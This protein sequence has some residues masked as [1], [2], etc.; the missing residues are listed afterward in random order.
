MAKIWWEPYSTQSNPMLGEL[1][2]P[3]GPSRHGRSSTLLVDDVYPVCR[4]NL[5]Q[6]RVT[7]RDEAMK[8]HL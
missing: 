4:G 2:E 3:P 1:G 6:V 7:D 5:L 8:A